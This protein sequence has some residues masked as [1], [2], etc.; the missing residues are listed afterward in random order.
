MTDQSSLF[1][2]PPWQRAII[3]DVCAELKAT[4]EGA[5]DQG[6]LTRIANEVRVSFQLHQISKEEFAKL[7]DL[8]KG[9]RK[10]LP[11]GPPPRPSV[12]HEVKGA[13][14]RSDD[15]CP[16]CRS[17]PVWREDL[18]QWRCSNCSKENRPKKKPP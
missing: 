8:G 4:I 3:R 10:I 6:S 12:A 11:P 13:L 18:R 7:A 16:A 17:E 2:P 15:R 14:A 9:L 5:A 1:G